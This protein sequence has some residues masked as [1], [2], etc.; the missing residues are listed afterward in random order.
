[1]VRH[2]CQ[3]CGPIVC[4]HQQRRHHQT[5]EP[6]LEY[7]LDHVAIAVPS[8]GA[9]L[10]AFELVSGAPGSPVETVPSQGVNVVFV[11]GA[12]C[13]LELLEPTSPD[14]P[15]AR[16]LAKRGSGLHH[17]AYRV[18]DLEAVLTDLGNRGFELIDRKPR[19]GAHGRLIAFIHPRS[20][21]GVLT[22]L[23]Q[24]SQPSP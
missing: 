7:P 22:E 21:N 17:I 14:S 12:G 10:P 20:T 23:V 1:L 8:L 13:R 5:T 16:F 2:T 15:V 11:G 24:D 6:I 4:S 19:A 18:T 3:P 9:A